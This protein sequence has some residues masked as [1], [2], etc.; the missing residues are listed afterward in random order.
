MAK[1]TWRQPEPKTGSLLLCGRCN[2]LRGQVPDQPKGTEQLC[3]CTPVEVRREQPSWGGDHNTY[4]ELCRCCGLV[5][6]KSGSRWSVWLC[7]YCKPLV[8]ALNRQSG[9]CVVPLGRHSLMNGIGL[10]ASDF[11]RPDAIA[12]FASAS[13]GLFAQ[14][15]G[16]DGYRRSVIA[17]NRRVLG[18][19]PHEDVYLGK[20]LWTVRRSELTPA[21]AFV[22]LTLHLTTA[23]D[24]A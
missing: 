8:M 16:L 24:S 19:E 23:V 10:R 7:D 18:F 6:L 22:A 15:E 3:R 9:R 12:R 14:V 13:R 4:A 21:A 5:L 17:H 2:E 1:Q 20:Y 11:E